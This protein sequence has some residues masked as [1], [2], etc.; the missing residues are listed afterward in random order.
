MFLLQ[1]SILKNIFV[2]GR[3]TYFLFIYFFDIRSFGHLF[4]SCSST[5]RTLAVTVFIS[6]YFQTF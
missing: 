2:L 4:H 5:R 6:L 3:L 1:K